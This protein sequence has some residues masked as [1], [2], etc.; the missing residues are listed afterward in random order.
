MSESTEQ[1]VQP[2]VQMVI[3]TPEE[4]GKLLQVVG[5]VQSSVGAGA[6]VFMANK[7]I[8]TITVHEA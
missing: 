4:W 2:K 6:F 1:D 3:C 8:A 5:S 7:T